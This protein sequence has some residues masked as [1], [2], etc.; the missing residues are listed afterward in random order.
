MAK[1]SAAEWRKILALLEDR[2]EDF[3]L[4]K[5]RSKS[6]VLASFNIRKIGKVKSKSAQSWEFMRAFCERCDLI[7]VQEVQDDLSGIQHLKSLLGQT[8][9][10]DR[11]G[12]VASDITGWGVTKKSMVERLAFLYRWDRVSRT[13][14]ASDLTYDRTALLN[15]LFED[16]VDFWQDLERR[17]AEMAAWAE[18][19]EGRSKKS[20]KPPF[21]LSNFLTFIRTPLCTSF[22]VPGIGDAEPYEFLTVNAHLLYGNKSKQRHERELEFHAL[23]QWMI[24]RAKNVKKLYH[25]NLL[26]LGDLNLDFKKADE[27]RDKIEADIKGL[28]STTFGSRK[29]STV[30]FPFLSV[31]PERNEVFRSTARLTETYDQIGFFSHDERLPDPDANKTA[32]SKADGFDYGV[33]NFSDLFAQAIHGESFA[34]LTKSKQKA[35]LKKYEHDVSDHLPIWVRLPRPGA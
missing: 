25:K 6:V 7:A 3:G 2:G 13:E 22:R 29:A 20:T 14:V 31:H 17:V 24:E 8:S 19:N 32:G 12:L 1:F 23:L 11:Y 27:R 10:Q 16:R 15:S 35:L 18:R 30:N 4:P 26:L 5:R 34:S 21:V 28:N 9:G 33:F